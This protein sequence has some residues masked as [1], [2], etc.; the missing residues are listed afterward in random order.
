M[1]LAMKIQ[2]KT[3]LLS[4][5]DGDLSRM[6]G[7]KVIFQ[8][9]NYPYIVD[10]HYSFQTEKYAIIV[11]DLVRGG[12]L[13]ELLRKHSGG[14]RQD[15]VILFAAEMA[16]ALNHLHE[17]GLLY[18]D[19][20]PANVLLTEKGHI[21]LA[22]MGLASGLALNDAKK[23]QEQAEEITHKE[24]ELYQRRKTAVLPINLDNSK[25]Y[26]VEDYTPEKYR[27][28]PKAIYLRR[29]TTVGTKGYM[30]PEMLLGKLKRRSERKGYNHSVDYWALGVTVFELLCG[31]KPFEEPQKVKEDFFEDLQMQLPGIRNVRQEVENEVARMK[32]EIEYPKHLSSSA[33]SFISRLLDPNPN[34]RL[35]C[36]EKG[37]IEIMTHPFF[38]TIQ[39]DELVAHNVQSTL[40]PNVKP[41]STKPKYSSFTDMMT[42]LDMRDRDAKCT[43]L[44]F[45]IV[46][47]KILNRKICR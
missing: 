43:Y 3:G 26:V 11:L 32:Q 16:L 34:T 31:F 13:R 44:S 4:E 21:N 45:T 47:T 7:E 39:W 28:A 20:K 5:H 12:D 25:N 27:H 22:D 1:V 19:L 37:F 18:R 41:I 6:A 40:S 33:K 8:A 14:L 35:G 17:M 42:K 36:S 46:F 30:A 2:L 10:M 24:E 29:K 9:C 38:K 15:S 23:L